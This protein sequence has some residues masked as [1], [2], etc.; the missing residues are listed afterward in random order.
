MMATQR[1]SYPTPNDLQ[2]CYLTWQKRGF[3]G[4]ISVVDLEMERL[5][6]TIE[7][8]HSNHRSP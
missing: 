8:A 7:W 3:A 4:V 5:S 1:H 2:I 6:W